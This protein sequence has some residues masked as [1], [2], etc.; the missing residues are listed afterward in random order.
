MEYAKQ[1]NNSYWNSHFVSSLMA[2]CT[3]PLSIQRPGQPRFSQTLP[4]SFT[5]LVHCNSL[6]YYSCVFKRVNMTFGGQK[7]SSA[8]CVW[9]CRARTILNIYEDQNDYQLK[10]KNGLD[11]SN[12]APTSII[13]SNSYTLWQKMKV[14]FCTFFLTLYP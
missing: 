1:I 2:V 14:F 13:N 4:I 12:F 8:G 7:F 10:Q 5:L 9:A 3:V 11:F 6:K